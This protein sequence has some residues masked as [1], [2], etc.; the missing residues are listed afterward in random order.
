MSK[1]SDG[2]V[3]ITEVAQALFRSGTPKKAAQSLKCSQ[4]FIYDL[5]SK[6]KDLVYLL[7]SGDKVKIGTT[8]NLVSRVKALRTS[9]P[10]ARIAL[11]LNG[12]KSTESALHAKYAKYRI[13]GEW[14]LSNPV[15]TDLGAK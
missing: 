9:N 6:Q 4:T 11:V 12:N 5:I 14:F 2:A 10:E 3:G 1:A 7:V 15:L 8:S 13:S